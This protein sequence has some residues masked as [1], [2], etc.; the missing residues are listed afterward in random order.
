MPEM[1]TMT[2]DQVEREI[3]RNNGHV[4]PDDGLVL[5]DLDL[6][7]PNPW[8]PRFRIDAD[9]VEDMA[10][11][12][13]GVGLLQE[14][15][16]RPVDGDRFQSAFGH[17]RIEAVRLLRSQG[18]WGDQ[19]PAKLADISDEQ[20]AYMALAENGTRKDISPVE[21]LTAWKNALEIPGV[22]ITELAARVG[23]D[24]TTMSSQ[25]AVLDLP[26]EALSLVHQGDMKVGA[27]RE[28]LA[29]RT[30]D[31][32]HDDMIRAVLHDCGS[33]AKYGL[34]PPADYRIKTVR[35]S[36]I[37][38]TRDS[39]QRAWSY[40]VDH[41]DR[42]WRPLEA[43]GAMT[44]S[45]DVAQFK[46]ELPESVH[47]LPVGMLSGGSE[48]TCD[49]KEW[50][51]RQTAATRERNQGKAPAKSSGGHTDRNLEAWLKVVRA[52][53]VVIEVLGKSRAKQLDPARGPLSGEESEALGS[54][55]KRMK[56]SDLVPLPLE[57]H[58][59][60]MSKKLPVQV[61][62]A[63]TPP[64]FD[65]EECRTCPKA[66]WALPRG[67]SYSPL[68]QLH[69]SDPERYNDKKAQG[70][71]RLYEARQEAIERDDK[72]DF[73][74][75][76][77]LANH[78]LDPLNAEMIVRSM[79]DWLGE[80]TPMRP[81]D[82]YARSNYYPQ[83]AVYFAAAIDAALPDAHRNYWDRAYDWEQA[84]QRFLE[85]AGANAP[86]QQLAAYALT[87]RGRVAYG[88]GVSFF[89]LRRGGRH[90]VG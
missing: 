83:V 48:W 1:T 15:L 2:I 72:E 13:N 29:L 25:L 19:V 65:F 11:S 73:N 85:E 76:T 21:T 61:R 16:L 40:T 24:R 71:E 49:V 41:P 87:W 3:A 55:I 35:A 60:E 32:T 63:D 86:W 67:Y 9:E 54:R 39:P 23:I 56:P 18:K 84:L 26:D 27:A 51:R 59:D 44:P 79:A 90:G 42:M 66:T 77:T 47:T 12:I 52:D 43:D 88:M 80:G 31:H 58:P 62:A 69:C 8:Q 70:W 46:A 68:V 22:T 38:L 82:G 36:I 75:V 5:I 28:L 14:P 10:A 7:D 4:R 64:L 45:F 17:R 33:E 6:I 89:K 30:A 53:P 81:A 74:V 50:R 20:M 78:Q 57:A 34:G 37:G